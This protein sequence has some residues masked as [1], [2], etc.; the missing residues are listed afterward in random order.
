MRCKSASSSAKLGASDEDV[1]SARAG[2]APGSGIDDAGIDDVE[3]DGASL[4]G[5]S[6][7]ASAG[8]G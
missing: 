4:G 5:S 8:G 6:N 2:R 1:E 3:L 7:G